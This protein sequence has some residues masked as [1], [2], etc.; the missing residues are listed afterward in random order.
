ML[1]QI[2]GSW[3][4]RQ[5]IPT[6]LRILR[7]IM[8]MFKQ[9]IHQLNII[10]EY[11]FTE[12]TFHIQRN[13]WCF[14]IVIDRSVIIIFQRYHLLWNVWRNRFRRP[15]NFDGELLNRFR[16]QLL[17][18]FRSYLLRWFNV[19]F[20]FPVTLFLLVLLSSRVICRFRC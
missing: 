15:A 6:Q 9:M 13:L 8:R 14:R 2:I 1:K 5:T 7:H 20:L 17:R 12:R 10:I 4:T 3:Y 19:Q 11:R 18:R 16:R